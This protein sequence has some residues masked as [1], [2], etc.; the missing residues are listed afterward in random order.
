MTAQSLHVLLSV[1]ERSACRE[2]RPPK[3]T[4]SFRA[5]A[6]ALL[7]DGTALGRRLLCSPPSLRA[8]LCLP[9]SV[10]ADLSSVLHI[11]VVLFSPSL[12]PY[13]P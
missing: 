8:A 7:G 2:A 4:E 10:S 11:S 9:H 1:L 3:S 13:I 5:S 6:A 12:R